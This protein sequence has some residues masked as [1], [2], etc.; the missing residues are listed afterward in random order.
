MSLDTLAN[1]KTRLGV[2]GSADDALLDLL[3]GSADRWVQSFTGRDLEGGT[4]TEYH[5]GAARFVQLA[6][7]P[8][9]AVG[10]VNVDP[11]GL[12]GAAT[13]LPATAYVVHAGRGVIQCRGGPFLAAAARLGLV[14]EDLADW[15]VGLRSVEVVY[16]T[17]TGAVPE[18]VKEAYAQLVGHWYRRVKTQAAAG[19]VNATQQKL[20]DTFTSYS[21][22][23]VAGLPVP[24]DVTRLLEPYR[25]P[26]V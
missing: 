3:R 18:D 23:Q 22:D 8:V 1:V 10:S 17:G 4:F 26:H 2:T 6:N 16:T 25:T 5:P 24:P 11:A 7:F 13:V 15:T 21:I 19:F 12:F 9:T 14:N 20:G